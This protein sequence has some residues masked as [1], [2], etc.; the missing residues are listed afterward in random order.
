VLA[1]ERGGAEHWLCW[2]ALLKVELNGLSGCR[3]WQ[4]QHS[5]MG[6]GKVRPW[7]GVAVRIDCLRLQS[8]QEWPWRD[9]VNCVDSTPCQRQQCSKCSR[10]VWYMGM[11]W[12]CKKCLQYTRWPYW[13]TRWRCGEMRS[14]AKNILE[15]CLAGCKMMGLQ[16]ISR[17]P[18]GLNI[19]AGGQCGCQHRM[20]RCRRAL[21]YS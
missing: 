21:L 11:T 19:I 7:R 20:N 3:G 10:C 18:L 9:K 1:V 17:L 16:G 8:S 5:D 14:N 13:A 6:V 4:W 2:L 12:W 15:F